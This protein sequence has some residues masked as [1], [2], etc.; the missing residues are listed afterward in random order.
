MGAD[1]QRWK[2]RPR[3]TEPEKPFPSEITLKDFT[4][5]QVVYYL[6]KLVPLVLFN[7]CI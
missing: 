5:E 4:E 1:R 6:V 2:G 7:G 3:Q